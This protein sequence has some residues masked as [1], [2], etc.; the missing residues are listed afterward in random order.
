MF[1]QI[2][3]MVFKYKHNHE[4]KPILKSMLRGFIEYDCSPWFWKFEKMV[5]VNNVQLSY[6]QIFDAS[7]VS[8]FYNKKRKILPCHINFEQISRSS[9]LVIAAELFTE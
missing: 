6:G 2:L 4:N 3:Q 5:N 7:F 8:L 1:V 9:N